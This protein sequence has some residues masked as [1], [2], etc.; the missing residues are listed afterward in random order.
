MSEKTNRVPEIELMKAVAIIGMI[1]VLVMRGSQDVLLNVK[2]LPGLVPYT[3]FEFLGGIPTAGVFMFAMGWGAVH[4]DR[5]TIKT[6]LMRA[7]KLLLLGLYVNFVVDILPGLIDP[8]H[9]GSFLDHPWVVI[10]FNIY[11]FAAISMIF[12]A[13][14]KWAEDHLILRGV[15]S[16]VVVLSIFAADFMLKPETFEGNPWLAVLISAFFRQSEFSW[17]PIVP[18]G[19][20]PV[21]GYWTGYLYRRWNNRFQF[22]IASLAVGVIFVPMSIIALNMKGHPLTAINPGSVAAAEYYSLNIWNVVC[23]IGIVCLEMALVFGILTLTKG[24]LP[25]IMADAS[26]HVKGMFLMQWVF[27]SPMMPLL[28][29]ITDV[30]INLLLGTIVLIATY[31]S[32]KLLEHLNTNFWLS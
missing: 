17:F 20:F 16:L 11:W 21:M 18:W 12:F 30:W 14:M 1:Y 13:I 26:R 5:S 32:V 27:I 7:L 22:M 3:F 8:E 10:I 23:A 4:S 25:W 9:F 19:I 28:L 29:N 6:F 24:Q 31:V 15:F 2:T